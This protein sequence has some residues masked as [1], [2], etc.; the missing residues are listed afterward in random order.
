M[1]ELTIEENFRLREVEERAKACNKAE[2]IEIIVVLTRQ[3][4]LQRKMTTDIM[5]RGLGF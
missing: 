4:M 3:N 1:L 5:K 2:L